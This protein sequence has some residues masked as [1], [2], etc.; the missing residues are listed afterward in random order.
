MVPK[1]NGGPRSHPVREDPGIGIS[2]PPFLGRLHPDADD[3][4]LREALSRAGRLLDD[5]GVRF[6][7][8]SRNRIGHVALPGPGGSVLECVVK[9]FR[10]RG[11]DKLKS[12]FLPSKARKAWRGSW[13]LQAAGIAT[14]A[15]VAFL[16]HRRGP[17][18]DRALFIARRVRDVVEVRPLLRLLRDQD[19]ES[20]TTALAAFARSCH[21]TG[22]L[23]RDLSDGN[24]LVREPDYRTGPFILVDTNRIRVK[25]RVRPAAGV[26]NLIRLGIPASQRRLFLA[27]YLNPRPRPGWLWW[28]Y[29]LNKSVFTGYTGLKTRLRIRE[30]VRKL[31]IQ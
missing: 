8:S 12:V 15:P 9:E 24:V 4:A 30:I 2:L 25:K 31:R 23:H 7:E 6:L 11:I 1:M 22:I 19:L 27:A 20:L 16:E 17:V 29:S 3:P 18:L 14:P 26:K 28:W 10:P 13:A 5:P 21:E